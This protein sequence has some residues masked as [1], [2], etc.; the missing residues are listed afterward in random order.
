M[1]SATGFSDR[2]RDRSS[3][4]SD[5]RRGSTS[6]AASAH[7]RVR[8]RRDAF[9]S[10]ACHPAS[11]ASMCVDWGLLPR[12]SRYG[13]RTT[14]A[15]SFKFVW[16]RAPNRCPL[17]L[18]KAL[19]RWTT[20]SKHFERR[21]SSGV[22]QFLTAADLAPER[23]KP[24]GDVVGRLRSTYVVRSV[25]G[26]LSYRNA[27]CTVVA[28]LGHRLVRESIDRR[29]VLSCRRVR[30]RLSVVHGSPRGG[31]QPEFAARGRRPWRRVLFWS[32]DHAARTERIA[33]HLWCS[34]DLDQTVVPAV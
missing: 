17:F 32:G 7:R 14:I 8:I 33:G 5:P 20:D 11:N 2:A 27:W 9:T 16:C 19:N 21:R 28:E 25:D 12:P 13:F 1:L 6:S 10:V 26:S 4:E 30:G 15:W 18:W 3:P 23:S 29:R 24:L 34:R 22:G 31:L